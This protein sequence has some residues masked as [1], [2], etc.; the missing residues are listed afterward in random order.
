MP[1]A[2]ILFIFL[3]QTVFSYQYVKLGAHKAAEGIFWSANDRFSANVEARIDEHPASCEL[4]ESRNQPMKTGIGVG[5][6]SLN[7]S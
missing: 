3:E 2:R 1:Q 5:V 7:A 6:D 4:L